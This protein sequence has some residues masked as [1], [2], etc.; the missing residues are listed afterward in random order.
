MISVSCTCHTAG[1]LLL[2]ALT[3]LLQNSAS[4]PSDLNILQLVESVAC[5]VIKLFD[6]GETTR[7]TSFF[8]LEGVVV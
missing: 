5:S 6:I 2:R 4:T 1:V 7:V 3:S 8:V